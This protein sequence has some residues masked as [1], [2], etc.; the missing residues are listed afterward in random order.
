MKG[1]SHQPR[2]MF[3]FLLQC[4]E[5]YVSLAE[6][7]LRFSDREQGPVNKATDVL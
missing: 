4:L 3:L 6:H 7:E 2:K 5:T 1:M